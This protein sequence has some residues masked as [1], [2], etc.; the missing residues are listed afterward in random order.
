MLYAA[1]HRAGDLGACC[2]LLTRGRLVLPISAAAAAGREPPSLPTAEADG[3]TW[4]VAYTSAEA[5]QAVT[6]EPHF[7]TV[8]LAELAAGWPDPRWGLAVDPGLDVHLQLESGTLARLAVPGLAEVRAAYPEA[9]PP[10]MQKVLTGPE[11]GAIRWIW[12]APAL[13]QIAPSGPARIQ[14]ASASTPA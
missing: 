3:T 11:K 14:R 4:L 2:V 12:F 8:A 5:M 13:N 1:A 10:V 9:M 6:G 7:T